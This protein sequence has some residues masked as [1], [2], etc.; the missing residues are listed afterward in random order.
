VQL[1]CILLLSSA[2]VQAADADAPPLAAAPFSADEAR[3]HQLAWAKHLGRAAQVTDSLG[4]KLRLIPPGT[5]MMGSPTDEQW[6]REDE[7]L[8][9]V[10]LTRPFYM[11]ATELTQS[12]YKAVMGENPSFCVGDT[13]PVDTVTW[14]QATEFC[15]KHSEREGAKY[16]L[17]TE[18]EW[19]YAC[20]AGTTTAFHTG[21][22][23]TT[24]QANYDGNHT[25]G[26]GPKGIFRETASAAGQ[27]PPNAW[28]IHE[29]HGNVWEWCGDW[30]GEY[31]KSDVRDPTGPAEGDCR[32]FR[33]GCWINFP[34]VCRSANRAKVVPV[35]WHFHLGFRVVRELE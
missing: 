26:D 14:E 33:G 24:E 25:Y 29:M 21:K 16:R 4:I 11:A 9:R 5:F 31:A 28:G 22:T 34:A 20:R 1:I 10:T 6:H 13:L 19:E 18:A 15:R 7:V 2:I 23:I 12:Q 32:V 27:F 35:S 17:P 8:H 30:Y 3:M